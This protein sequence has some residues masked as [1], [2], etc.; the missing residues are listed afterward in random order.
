MHQAG[1][2]IDPINAV[3][4]PALPDRRGAELVVAQGIRRWAATRRDGAEDFV[5]RHYSLKGS[6][7]LHGHALGW[8]VARAPVNMTLGAVQAGANLAAWAARK[9]GADGLSRSLTRR[10]LFLETD[11]GRQ[12]ERL[13]MTEFLE[14]PY[15]AEGGAPQVWR[16]G[17][18][19]TILSDPRLEAAFEAA[20]APVAANLTD[21]AFRAR[22]AETVAAYAGARVAATDIATALASLATGLAAFRQITPGVMSLTPLVARAIAHKAALG[23]A[24]VGLAL[25]ALAPALHAGTAGPWLMLG[26]G[27]G[28]VTA[29]A[30]LA[31][32]GGI[33]TDPIQAK[34]GLHQRRLVQL[35][36]T[37]EAQ[38]LGDEAAVFVARDHYVAR[39]LELVDILRAA[40]RLLPG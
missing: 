17:L 28:M 3:N 12:V 39:L 29:A 4:L 15:E 8:D 33:V 6:L 20:L 25:G 11:L 26:V 22:V 16:D 1:P 7:A 19:E 30:L 13:V 34:L 5:A 31:T 35:V 36:D 24:P 2:A 10:P 32:F 38:L 21:P 14:L 23:Q 37:I 40:R 9:A 18:A 27:T